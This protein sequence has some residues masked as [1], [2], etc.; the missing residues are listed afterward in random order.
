MT[1]VNPLD[2]ISRHSD[3]TPFPIYRAMEECGLDYAL[4]PLPEIVSGVMKRRED[5]GYSAIINNRH[6]LARQRFTAA[7]QLGHFIYHRD[8][9]NEGTVDSIN[10]RSL[11]ESPNHNALLLPVHEGQANSFAANVLMSAQVIEK[12]RKAGFHSTKEL[13]DKLGVA[14]GLMALRLGVPHS[15]RIPSA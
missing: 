1:A 8:I 15:E 11:T 7:H 12:L 14:H 6:P 4:R 10:Y 2:V 9:L 5:G 13:A 3:E